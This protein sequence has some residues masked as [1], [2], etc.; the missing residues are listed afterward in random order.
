M[1]DF[2]IEPPS[3]LGIATKSEMPV[4]VETSWRRM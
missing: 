2:K 1:S 3:L 4:K